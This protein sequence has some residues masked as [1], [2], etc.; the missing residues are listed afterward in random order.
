MEPQARSSLKRPYK[1]LEDAKMSDEISAKKH[2]PEPSPILQIFQSFQVELDNRHDKY[3]RIV[4]SSR[5][6]T[7]QSKRVIFLLHRGLDE[8]TRPGILKEAEGKFQSIKKLFKSVAL[9]LRDE[10]PYQFIRAYSPGLQEFIEAYSFW[11]FLKHGSLVLLDEVCRELVFEKEPDEKVALKVPP[12]EYVLGIAD[13]T[14]ELMR[15]AINSVGKGSLKA[16]LQICQLLRSIHEAFIT[17]GNRGKGLSK[18]LEVMTSSL[19]KVE[20][21]CYTIHIRGSEIPQNMLASLVASNSSTAEDM[22]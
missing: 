10:D 19:K 17:F 9:E 21:T 6:V 16:P 15:L 13:L 22:T 5:D 14:G 11:Y 4:K 8:K 20:N 18:K 2:R 7:I 3:E 12:V 1:E